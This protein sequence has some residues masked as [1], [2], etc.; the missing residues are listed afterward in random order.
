M[1]NKVSFSI[2]GLGRVIDKRIFHMFKYEIKNAYVKN[3]YDKDK[4]KLKK[5]EK[6]FNCKA[7]KSLESFLNTKSDFVYIATES[8][9][10]FKHILK[11]FYNNKNVIVEKPPVLKVNDLEILHKIAKKK[12]LK[13]YTIFQNRLNKSVQHAKKIIKTEEIIFVDL[14]LIWSRPQEYYNDWH[15]KW[16]LDGGVLAQQ[17]IHYVDLLIYLFG[18]PK[19]CISALE[20]RVNNLQAEDTHSSLIV[21]KKK[22]LSCTV[23]MSTGFRP[24][25][26]EASI[27]IYCKKKVISL[28]GLCCN[29][30]SVSNLAKKNNKKNKI[31]KKSSEKVPSGYGISHKKVFQE[32]INYK[33]K[34][35]ANPLKAYET[36]STVKLINMMYKSF[37]ED[38]WIYFDE[39]KI[40]SKLGK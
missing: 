22:N 3:I 15:G 26:F 10:H 35:N 28:G 23:N 25:D 12:N 34:K 24:K 21:F 38:R 31:I 39:K 33:L 13:F 11:C 37:F 14:S 9:N 5:Y 8:G 30:I 1:K 32:I 36:L 6:L 4:K 7:E 40:I 2:L 27:K 16:H 29:T 20:N 18:D 19:K 17:G